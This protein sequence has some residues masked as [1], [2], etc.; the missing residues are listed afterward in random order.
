MRLAALV[1]AL[2]AFSAH[3]TIYD[4]TANQAGGG[5]TVNNGDFYTFNPY[6]ADGILW[7][8]DATN[9]FNPQSAANIESVIE[10]IIGVEITLVGQEEF[11]GTRSYSTD[12]DANIYAIHYNGYELIVGYGVLQ[13]GFDI[14]GLSHDFSNMRAYT[15]DDCGT[16]GITSTP[17]PVPGAALL[18]GSA[19]M[20][21][22]GVV[23]K[24]RVS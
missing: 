12:V 9:D 3:A 13:D 22:A 19:L 24:R 2:V 5:V 4:E 20:G 11:D 14:S 7:S 6:P 17:V 10:G 18:M 15:C 1:L 16:F 8:D 23:R 21:L